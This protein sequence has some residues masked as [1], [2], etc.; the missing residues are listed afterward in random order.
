MKSSVLTTCSGRKF[1]A[2]IAVIG[3]ALMLCTS[4][5]ALAQDAPPPKVSVMAAV[6]KPIRNY[7]TFIVRVEAI[8]KVNVISRVSGFLGDVRV[9]E[10]AGVHAGYLLFKLEPLYY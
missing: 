10:V 2:K 8:D 4:P 6:T 5:L 7:A 9:E 1:A 3:T